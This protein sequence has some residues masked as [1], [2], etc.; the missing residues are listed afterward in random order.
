F[1]GGAAAA[2]PRR[3]S[4]KNGIPAAADAPHQHGPV[5]SKR[6]LGGARSGLLGA[7]RG[8]DRSGPRSVKDRSMSPIAWLRT[9]E[10]TMPGHSWLAEERY[11]F[12]EVGQVSKY[13]VRST[14]ESGSS[15]SA[16]ASSSRAPRALAAESS[17]LSMRKAKRRA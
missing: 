11:Y 1:G 2:Q 13:A 17:K 10:W 4:R 15:G 5:S 8:A 9:P 7:T 16:P 6:G 12:E 14:V 3:R